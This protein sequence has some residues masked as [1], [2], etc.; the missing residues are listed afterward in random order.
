[1]ALCT[2]LEKARIG[3]IEFIKML[4]FMVSLPFRI[5]AFELA[6]MLDPRSVRGR[7]HFAS[8]VWCII[9]F[10]F[11]FLAESSGFGRYVPPWPFVERPAEL[12]LNDISCTSMRIHGVTRVDG[13]ALT[14]TVRMLNRILIEKYANGHAVMKRDMTIAKKQDADLASFLIECCAVPMPLSLPDALP[15]R[16]LC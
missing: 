2:M 13:M 3:K 4:W 1:M 8:H 11:Y 16:P 5:A 14:T 15:A 10:F 6:R 9:R 7:R 12:V